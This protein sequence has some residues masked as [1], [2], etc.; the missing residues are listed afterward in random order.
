MKIE[1]R[2]FQ[3]RA[4]VRRRVARLRARRSPWGGDAGSPAG[5]SS[6]ARW[7][8]RARLRRLQGETMRLG[9]AEASALMRPRR[10]SKC[11]SLRSSREGCSVSAAMTEPV[12]LLISLV[13][14]RGGSRA[15]GVRRCRPERAR[16][17]TGDALAVAIIYLADRQT[18]LTAR[19]VSHDSGSDDFARREGWRRASGP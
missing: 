1:G 7:P 17:A 19:V 8:V 4:C 5:S 12:M 11:A 10:A 16:L 9:D 13:H 2:G 14:T 6:S 18:T 15:V 3:L